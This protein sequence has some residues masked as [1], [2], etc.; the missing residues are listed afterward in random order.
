MSDFIPETILRNISQIK[1]KSGRVSSI[2]EAA[3]VETYKNTNL[4]EVNEMHYLEIDQ[5]GVPL[6]EG[7]A[8]A[9]TFYTDTE[10]AEISG[11]IFFYSQT[12]KVGIYAQT[13]SWNNETRFLTSDPAEIVTVARDD[14]SYV[15]GAGF[16]A[17][18]NLKEITFSAGVS[19]VYV[20]EDDEEN[21]E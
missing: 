2:L 12:E 1:V 16:K 7:W 19:G 5:E 11:D 6:T 14:G 21:E 17:D 4:M 13:L 18:L 3:R 10:N 15:R 20:D 9:S 8:D